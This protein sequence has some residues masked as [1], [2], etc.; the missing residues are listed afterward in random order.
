MSQFLSVISKRDL[1]LLYSNGP[2]REQAKVLAQLGP[3][4]QP[5]NKFIENERTLDPIDDSKLVELFLACDDSKKNVSQVIDVLHQ[6]SPGNGKVGFRQVNHLV[7]YLRERIF[8]LIERQGKHVA[9]HAHDHAFGSGGDFKKTIHATTNACI[10]AAPLVTI[11]KTGTTN[12]TSHHGSSQT[13]KSIGY[14]KQ[15]FDA[16]H[17]NHILSKY[18]FAFV[19]LVSLGFPYSRTLKSARKSFW[20]EAVSIINK[21]LEINQQN[22]QDTLKGAEIP[23]DIFKIVSPNAQVLDPL[24][25]STGVCHLSMIP[26]VLSIYL[27]LNS[28]GVIVHSYDGIDE[29][30]TA[31]TTYTLSSPNNLILKVDSDEVTILEFSPEDIGLSRTTIEAI[32]EEEIVEDEASDFWRIISGVE[33]GPKRDFITANVAALLVAGGKISYSDEGL[34]GQ[35]RMGVHIAE[36]LIDSGKSY[37][38][39][40]KLIADLHDNNSN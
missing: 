5:F 9:L 19:S 28:K 25:H 10:V 23:I 13:I 40:K 11:C 30:S 29:I 16:N 26:Y 15:S 14:N 31:S 17:I 34:V 35:L 12:V 7:D 24:H 2:T 6:L 8:R 3:L 37:E 32:Q 39:F 36:E 38:N 22:W 18:G 33:R 4:Q 27:H 20:N 1:Q 21:Q